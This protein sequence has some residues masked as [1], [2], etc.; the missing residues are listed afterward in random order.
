M[1]SHRAEFDNARKALAE[2]RRAFAE[3]ARAEVTDEA[4]I[5]A[6]GSAIANAM[7]DDAILRAR[8]RTE[9]HNLLTAEQQQQ[10][11]ERQA[12]MQKRQPM[13]RLAS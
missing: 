3:A 1:Q 12:T 13:Q 7:A 6:H 2:A 8:V 4:A 11:K 9:V 5:R 10:L